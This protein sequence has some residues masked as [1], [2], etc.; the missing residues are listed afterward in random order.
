MRIG[1]RNTPPRTLARPTALVAAALLT[2]TAF[3]P[4]AQATPPPPPSA[5]GEFSSSFEPGQPAPD[6]TDTA[7]QDPGGHPRTDGVTPPSGP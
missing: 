4:A 3:G 2:V 5:A 6:W 7:D 1:H